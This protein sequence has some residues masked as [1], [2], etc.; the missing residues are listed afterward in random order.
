MH[1]RNVHVTRVTLI[2]D[3]NLVLCV[4]TLV[5]LLVVVQIQINAQ[6]VVPVMQRHTE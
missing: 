6:L 1:L 3:F 5:R 2:T 4:I